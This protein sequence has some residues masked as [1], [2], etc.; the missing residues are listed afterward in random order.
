MPAKRHCLWSPTCHVLDEHIEKSEANEASLEPNRVLSAAS[1]QVAQSVD[2]AQETVTHGEVL[3]LHCAFSRSLFDLCAYEEKT[4]G[5]LSHVS[6]FEPSE[7][8]AL[9]KMLFLTAE[10]KAMHEHASF[11]GD[12]SGKSMYYL[13]EDVDLKKCYNQCRD[14]VECVYMAYDEHAMTCVHL[15]MWHATQLPRTCGYLLSESNHTA[16]VSVD[17]ASV[18]LKAVMNKFQI[19][20]LSDVAFDLFSNSKRILPP[21]CYPCV[22][23]FI[24]DPKG[25]TTLKCVPDLQVTHPKVTEVSGLQVQKLI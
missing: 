10:G 11:V 19:Y 20:M 1:K 8:E 18:A 21:M 25:L 5:S 4:L 12:R 9:L 16:D 17:D 15:S 22:D 23:G 13:N 7:G 2:S 14:D 6:G 24:P 3:E